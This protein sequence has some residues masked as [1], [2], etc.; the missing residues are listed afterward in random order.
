MPMPMNFART[1]LLLAVLTGILVAMGGVV[2]GRAGMLFALVVAAAMNLFSYWRSDSLVLGMYGAEEVDARSGGEYYRIVADLV[3]RAGLPM[4]RVYV[5]HNPQPNAF[6]TGRNPDHAAVCASTGLLEMLNA[7][8]VRG[9]LAHELAHIKNRDT[10][11]MAVAATIGGAIS[12]LAQ[13]LKFGALFGGQRNNNSLGWIGALAAMIIAPL[14]A[15]LV[16]MAVSRSREYQADRLGAMICGQ[17]LW[18]ASALGKIEGYAH[19]IRNEPAEAAPAT[20]HLF[21]IN[22]LSGEG[23]DN[24]FSTHPNTENRIAELERLAAE[25]GANSASRRDAPSQPSS[26]PWGRGSSTGPRGPWG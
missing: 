8:E 22:P 15:M 19:Q 10:L 9:V 18:L 21:I 4:P 5:M 3:A 6:A 12:M 14:A 13:Y 23:M 17:P 25:I 20:A 11:T 7:Q 16:Q 24:L 2:G 1:G 26:G